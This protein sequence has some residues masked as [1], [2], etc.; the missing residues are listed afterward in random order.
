MNIK[1]L[2]Y[3]TAA[4]VLATVTLASP[5]S[6]ASETSLHPFTDVGERYDEA[7]GFFYILELIN[8]K[9][10][11]KFGTGESLTRGDAAVILANTLFLDTDNAK[12]AGF[13]DL[14]T[15]VRGAVNALAEVGIVSGVTK[16]E[17]QPAAP[18]S[19][20]AMA[21]FLTTA[22][23]LDEFQQT[24]PFSDV[25]GV[26]KPYIEALYGAEI[27]SGKTPTT[28]GTYANITRGEYANLLYK[29]IETTTDWFYYPEA[30][31]VKV[32]SPTS[33]VITLS[34]PA[35]EGYSATEIA[36][37]FD[38]IVILEDKTEIPVKPSSY[39]LSADRTLLTI[40]HQSLTGKSGQFLVD[41][42]ITIIK[43]AFNFKQ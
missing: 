23:E 31:N 24:T 37:F 3:T 18:L 12:D 26:F 42:Y 21:K 13:K 2:F 10:P 36:E 43:S 25:G 39:K 20:G 28:Y 11:T 27:T 15:R 1:K 7:V 38:F 30:T 29:T 40:E 19:R 9:S 34:E 6:A 32:V 17:F 16:D 14:N 22:F 5:T 33:T 4:I 35:F 8:G 41:D